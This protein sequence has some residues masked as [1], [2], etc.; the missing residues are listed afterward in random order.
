VLAA[1]DL[2]A[3]GGTKVMFATKSEAEAAARQFNC[4]GAHNM[5]ETWMSCQEYPGP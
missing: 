3:Q 2:A 4:K 5:G 1:P